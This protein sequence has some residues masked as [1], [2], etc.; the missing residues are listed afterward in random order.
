MQYGDTGKNKVNP[1]QS[2]PNNNSS[3]AVVAPANNQTMVLPNE[4]EHEEEKSDGEGEQQQ[5][6]SNVVVVRDGDGGKVLVPLS[7]LQSDGNESSDK[8]NF[9]LVT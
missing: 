3:N 2:N 1:S 9:T 8:S 6:P 4:L 7:S 5:P